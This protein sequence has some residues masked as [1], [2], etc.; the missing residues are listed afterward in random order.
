MDIETVGH[1]GLLVR[2]DQGTPVLFTDP[3]ISGSCYWR[4]W[5]LQN[6]PAPELVA[7]LQRSRYCVI[8]HEHPDHNPAELTWTDESYIFGILILI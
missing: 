2:D 8:T 5:W 6:Y 1:A 3:W 7:E 4:S